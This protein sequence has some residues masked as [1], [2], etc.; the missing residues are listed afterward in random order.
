MSTANITPPATPT[1]TPAA[2]EAAAGAA[3]NQTKAANGKTV[4][5][6]ATLISLLAKTAPPTDQETAETPA[7]NDKTKEREDKKA[8]TTAAALLQTA[9][10]APP[11]L[12]QPTETPKKQSTIVSPLPAGEGKD[13]SPL[14][15]T[16][17][18]KMAV[19]SSIAHNDK[20]AVGKQPIEA[21]PAKSS[22]DV[23]E[24]PVVNRPSIEPIKFSLPSISTKPV[25]TPR[26][27]V[28][29][30]TL[31][32]S[33]AKQD[34]QM[35]MMEKTERSSQSAEK[36]LPRGNVLPET[37]AVEKAALPVRVG[38]HVSRQ[39]GSADSRLPNAASVTSDKPSVA[40]NNTPVEATHSTRAEKAVAEIT[41]RIVAFRKIGADTLD[42][43]VKPDRSTE[44]SLHL[45]LRNGQVEVAA[46]LESGNLGGLQA[47]W[48]DLQQKLSQQGIRVG[49]LDP[50]LANGQEF[51][52]GATGGANQGSHQQ[53]SAHE[54][55]D[56]LPYVGTMT[57]PLKGALR[58]PTVAAG[59]G[60][61][62]WA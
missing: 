47:Q 51:S 28:P 39:E 3:A 4:T 23:P 49:Q 53:S 22:P 57:E 20:V 41:D 30:T 13:S 2:A 37:N 55:P 32:M 15:T 60:W 14:P 44:I 5:S 27:E 38:N 34:G 31:G 42:I 40:E 62:M 6:F 11:V 17:T 46:R 52:R 21:E 33:S 8:A 50:V 7:G 61:E 16:S 59:R 43:S 12:V 26:S 24:K 56:E 29:V 45:T 9:P 1:V 18:G 35:K 54:G 48:G 25:A 58:K 10:P 36:N 19:P